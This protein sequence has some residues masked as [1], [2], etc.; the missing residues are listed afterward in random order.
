MNNPNN[1]LAAPW[2]DLLVKLPSCPLNLSKDSEW[3]QE[4]TANG[5]TVE[6]TSFYASDQDII[7]DLSV[8]LS[9][10]N[11][12]VNFMITRYTNQTVSLA[13]YSK[14]FINPYHHITVDLTT[15]ATTIK[16]IKEF[17]AFL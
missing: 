2:I 12:K 1:L 14:P 9:T 5:F 16:H 6:H 8:L 11:S 10:N 13:C 4:A 3:L 17:G 15:F 7:A